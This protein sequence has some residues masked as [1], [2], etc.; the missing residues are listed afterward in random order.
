MTTKISKPTSPSKKH[1]KH[2]TLETVDFEIPNEKEISKYTDDERLELAPTLSRTLSRQRSDISYLTPIKSK[3]SKKTNNN[4]KSNNKEETA[5]SPIKKTPTKKHSK[6]K[7]SSILSTSKKH[8]SAMKL[9]KIVSFKKD[10]VEIIDVP[11]FKEYN[12]ES[13]ENNGKK[14]ISCNC[15]IY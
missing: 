5:S 3:N 8:S 6:T 15:M 11:S 7:S 9:K 4:K 14:E 12:V 1:K 2:N 13:A 10:F